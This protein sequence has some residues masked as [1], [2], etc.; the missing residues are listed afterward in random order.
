MKDEGSSSGLSF[1]VFDIA[2][3]RTC[4]MLLLDGL[5]SIEVRMITAAATLMLCSVLPA[6]WEDAG[7]SRSGRAEVNS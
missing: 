4:I 5:V 7:V 3:M 6:D 1:R 2:D